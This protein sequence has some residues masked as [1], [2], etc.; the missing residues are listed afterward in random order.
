MNEKIVESQ[1]RTKK[2][3]KRIDTFVKLTILPKIKHYFE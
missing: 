1:K 2:I 3:K